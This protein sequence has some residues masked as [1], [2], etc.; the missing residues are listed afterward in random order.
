[1]VDVHSHILPGMDDGSRCAAE[2]VAMLEASARQGV[3]YIAATPHFYAAENSP[4]QFL[5]R[6]KAAAAAL[7][8]VW[9]PGLPRLMLG[10]EVRYFDGISQAEE[11]DALKIG[12]TG[13]LLLEMPFSPWTGRMVSE[14]LELQSRR[15]TTVLLAHIER[16]LAF[17]KAAAWRVLLDSGVRTQCNAAFFLNWRTRRRALGMLL[18]GE[19]HFLASDCHNM[20]DRPPRLG[21]AVKEIDRSLGIAGKNLLDREAEAFLAEARGAVW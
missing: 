4:A 7:R 17:L 9:H 8:A 5:D 16:Y 2:S 21:D 18:R 14:V 15:G 12:D 3:E 1:M 6:R 20:A 10:A 13:F 11:A 19:I